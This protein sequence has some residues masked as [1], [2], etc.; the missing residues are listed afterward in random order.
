MPGAEQLDLLRGLRARGVR[1]RI[2]TNSLAS[3]DVPVVHAGYRRY[4]LPLAQAGVELFEVKPELGRPRVGRM[5]LVREP[6]GQ[7]SL[8]A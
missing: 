1:V 3:T 7:F 6:R 4:R 8:H 2:L 5:T